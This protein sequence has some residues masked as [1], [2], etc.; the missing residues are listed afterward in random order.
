[1]T[2]IGFSFRKINA[3]RSEVKSGKVNVSNNVSLKNVEEAS[4]PVGAAKQK[5]LKFTYEFSTKYEP[6]FGSI[7]IEGD[8]LFLS[9][10]ETV[11]K[12]IKEWKKN[13]KVDKEILTPILNTILN[14]CSIK[15]LLMSQDLN[16]PTPLQMPRVSVK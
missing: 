16:L 2:I 5:A 13:K 11:E 8:L 12:T 4:I 15:G 3:E 1:M 9:S 14:R 6:K 10:A 7:N